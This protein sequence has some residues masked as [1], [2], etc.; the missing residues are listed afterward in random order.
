MNQEKELFE[1]LK[2]I[3]KH[4]KICKSLEK[5]FFTIIEEQIN[6]EGPEDI[7]QFID[8]YSNEFHNLFDK[9]TVAMSWNF[10][11]NDTSQELNALQAALA[12]LQEEDP[13]KHA[14]KIAQI[15]FQIKKL[16]E[17]DGK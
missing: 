11:A 17:Q 3:E 1:I 12:E 13:I 10:N 4:A 2:E 8:G 14:T 15:E 16:E 9:V 7:E 5:R 6:V